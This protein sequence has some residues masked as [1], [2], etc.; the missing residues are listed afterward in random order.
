MKI[1]DRY[2]AKAVIA[3]SLTAFLVVIGLDVF[4]SLIGEIDEVGKGD[5]TLL[6][7]LATVA[8][9]VPHSVYELFPV[10]A[11][12][13]SL[14]GMG[15]LATSSELV[16]MRASGMSIWRI[17][18]SVMQAGI[19]MLIVV[20]ILG[21]FV[22]P[23]TERY[24]QEIRASATE[25]QVTFM[26]SRGLWV[27]TGNLYINAKRVIS[28]NALADVTVYEFDDDRRLKRVIR[29][30]HA[31]YRKGQWVMRNVSQT[32]FDGD[33]AHVT[34]AE[35]LARD[36]LLTPELL[37]IVVLEPE[38]MSAIDISQFMGYLE[39][40]G[41]NT[42]QYEYALLSRFV[43]PLSALVMLFIS[44]PFVFGGLRSVST[45]QRVFI[46]ILVGFGFYIVSQI[47]GQLGRVYELNP[48][49]STLTPS[50]IFLL[51]GIYAVR[52]L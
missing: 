45:G 13:G 19:I 10:A 28:G 48:V 9:T 27:R 35:K 11:L 7:M 12:L 40:N 18:Y 4:F 20:V 37:G 42:Q 6:K 2:I 3:G 50:L 32:G 34:Q 8:L 43:T 5:Y 22:A 33:T 41:L 16:A 30:V 23:V 52:R 15:A 14:T 36:S 24:A 51:I 1:I 39:D 49:L 25:T 38:N 17:V 46:A 44:V 21:E 29:A 26:G 31:R 47:A